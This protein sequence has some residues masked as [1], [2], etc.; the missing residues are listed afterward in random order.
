MNAFACDMALK[1]KY[2]TFSIKRGN[3]GRY[4]N[5]PMIHNKTGNG[6]MQI[7]KSSESKIFT[8]ALPMMEKW[9][10]EGINKNQVTEFNKIADDL[11]KSV[12]KD[13][14]NL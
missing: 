3:G 7:L 1:L 12:Y 11:V 9:R 8:M 6:Y 4:M 2:K 13:L 5:F 10:K 14:L